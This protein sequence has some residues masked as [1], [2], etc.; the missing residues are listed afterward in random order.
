VDLPDDDHLVVELG[1]NA[2]HRDHDL[3]HDLLAGLQEFAGGLEDGVVVGDGGGIG[4]GCPEPVE[5]GN[6]VGMAPGA[7]WI[8]CRNMRSGYG[9][10]A[11]YSECYEWFVAPTDPPST[12]TPAT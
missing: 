10:P 9:T 7:R 8:G 4:L 1:P 12:S 6:Q 5:C 2:G 3:G 11:T